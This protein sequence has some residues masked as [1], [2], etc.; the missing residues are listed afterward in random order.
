MD[1]LLRDENELAYPTK[2]RCESMG[3]TETGGAVDE[4]FTSMWIFFAALHVLQCNSSLIWPYS[5]GQILPS[6]VWQSGQRIFL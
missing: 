2:T 1:G 5:I 3:V 4:A 6:V